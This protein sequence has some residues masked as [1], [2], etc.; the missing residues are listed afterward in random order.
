MFVATDNSSM[1]AIPL[2]ILAGDLMNNGG[3]TQSIMRFARS[4]VGHIRGGLAHVTILANM[5]FAAMSGSAN[6]ACACMGSMMIP[7]M[8]EDGYDD[9]FACAVTAASSVLGPIIPPSIIFVLYGSVTG[10]NVNSLL[11]AGSLIGA[12]KV[13]A[14]ILM[15]TGTAQAF[16][17]V[18]TSKQIPQKMAA[19]IMSFSSSKATFF[20][21]TV[22]CLRIIGCFIVETATVP[23]LAPLFAPLAGSFQTDPVHFGVIFVLLVCIG[24]LTP[25]MG[26]MLFVS[27]K[28]GRIP[29]TKIV[30]SLVPFLVAIAACI[31]LLIVLPPIITSLPTLIG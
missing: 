10:T 1:L 25:P 2:F 9:G 14:A 18:L 8:N 31:T 29:V 26:S 23:I 27:S 4:L 19:A 20:L 21:I 5:M 11:V 13:T 3:I 15:V 12:A 28:V 22:V 7:S 30:K 6:A 16:A 17:W 24:S